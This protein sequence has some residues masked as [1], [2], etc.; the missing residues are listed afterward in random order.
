MEKEEYNAY[1]SVLLASED[2]K[3]QSVGSL[4]EALKDPANDFLLEQ[5]FAKIGKI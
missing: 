4:Q 1:D 5:F 3:Q 2:F